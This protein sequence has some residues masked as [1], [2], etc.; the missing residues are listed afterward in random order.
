MLRVNMMET[1]LGFDEALRAKRIATARMRGN[2]NI[3]IHQDMPAPQTPR[4]TYARLKGA[5]VTAVVVI[6]IGDPVDG[7]RCFHIGYAVR[8]DQRG[9]GVAKELV[10]A[11]LNDFAQNMLKSDLDEL[12]FEASVDQNNSASVA[13]A[14]AVLDVEPEGKIDDADGTPIWHYL[15]HVSLA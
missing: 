11:A 9:K 3:H 1:L 7:V 14:K 4:L 6:T 5:H 12:W 15:K 13:V 8:E 10:A 2:E